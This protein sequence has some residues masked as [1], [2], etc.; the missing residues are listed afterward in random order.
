MM[1][2]LKSG[3]VSLAISE[4]LPAFAYLKTAEGAGLETVG[5][6][7]QDSLLTG[8]SYIVVSK[9]LPQLVPT[10]NRAL[11]AIRRS[12][13]YARINRKYFDFNIY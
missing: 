5:T 3:K 6:P 10:L 2:D 11:D 7:I 12:G 8:P 1:N 13:E 9:K 4:G